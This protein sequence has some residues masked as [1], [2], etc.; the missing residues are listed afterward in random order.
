MTVDPDPTTPPLGRQNSVS[1]LQSWLT[2]LARLPEIL[3]LLL[4]T[5][6]AVSS[7]VEIS[8]RQ[9]VQI[10]LKER[11]SEVLQESLS[12]EAPLVPASGI[13][14]AAGTADSFSSES[15]SVL[16]QKLAFLSDTLLRVRSLQAVGADTSAD[17]LP[18]LA[19]VA[20][21]SRSGGELNDI[22]IP[23]VQV[24]RSLV[25]DT[26]GSSSSE[27]LL[28]LTVCLSGLIGALVA[29]LRKFEVTLP[30]DMTLGIAA[31]FIVYLGIKGGKSVFLLQA[32]DMGFS[33]NPYGCAFAGI[34]VG[35]FTERAYLLL[36]AILD[37]FQKK[38]LDVV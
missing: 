2:A 8:A 24:V 37:K 18:Q 19:G 13:S 34:L 28:A 17:V 21:L 36:T 11:I 14:A 26:I 27:M 5:F 35:L 20:G 23:E 9:V 12:N 31:G 22:R 15:K 25:R 29:G 33:M 30:K 10:D 6:V 1:S 38:V 3:V 7:I 4:A 16:R 32:Q